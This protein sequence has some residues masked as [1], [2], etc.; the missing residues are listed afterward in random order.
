[1]TLL[2]DRVLDRFE[3]RGCLVV[4]EA[5]VEPVVVVEVFQVCLVDL[6]ALRELLRSAVRD[7]A[8]EHACETLER[9]AFHDAQLVVQVEAVALQFVVD[10]L[11]R[12]LVALDAFTREHLDVDHRAAHARRHAQRRVL[13]VRRLLAED[14]AQQLLFR[15]QLG[16]A[17]RRHLADQ[18]VARFDFRTDVHDARFVETAKLDFR[19]VRDIARDFFR[20]E[21]RVACDDVQLFDVDRRVAIVRDD[22]LRDQDRILEVVA[23]PRHERDQHVLA[24]RELAQVR[25]RAVGQHV[26]ARDLVAHLHDRTLIDVRV[27]V[28]TRVLDQVIDVDADFARDRFVIVHANDDTARVDVIDDAAAQRLHRRARVD[29]HGTLDA[30]TDDGLLRTQTRHGLTLHVRAHQRTVRIVVLEE[31][32]QRGCNRHDLRRRDV[33][34]LDAVRRDHHRFAGFTRRHEFVDERAIVADR[35]VCLRD[36][37]AAFLDRRQ[38]V[39]LVGHLAVDDLAVRRLEEAVFVQVRI[40]RERV[41]ETDVRT[42]RR[43]DRAHAAVVGRVHVADFEARAL[44]RQ[45]ARAQCG[46]AAL[47]RDFRQRVGL[48]HELRQLRRAEE[49]ANRRRNR[50]RVDQVVRHQVF[51]LGLAEALLH[52]AFD[53]HEARAELVFRQF[54]DAAHAPVAEVVDVVDFALAVAQLDENLD[55]RE[56]VVVLQRHRAGDFVTADAAVELHAADLRQVV[57]VFAVEQAIE[58][59]LDGFFRRRLARTHHPVDRDARGRLVDGFVDTQRRRDVRTLVQ[60]V[61]VERLDFLD[62]RFAQLV[63]HAF[64][65]LVVGVRDHFARIAVDDV[66]RKHAAE[67]IVFGHRDVLGLRGFEIANVLRVD[68]L[69]LLDDDLAFTI[70]DVEAC[71]FAAQ[72]LGHELHLRAFVHQREVVEDEEVREDLLRREADRLQQDRDRHLATAVDAEVQH[73]LRIEFEV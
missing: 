5:D 67:Q 34:V 22:A 24:E 27:L 19:E 31:R 33:H 39:D 16:F 43:F 35:R 28:R 54:A 9:V 36:H 14:R 6:R 72:A 40:Q 37:V 48:V 62:L 1:M 11:L 58:Q 38:I 69:V 60:I 18:H 10:D 70:G 2:F 3:L 13:H 55:R 44:A 30:G 73:V 65:D 61:R 57:R 51:A 47:V 20:P 66:L 45:T 64:R 46:N 41:D 23:V 59:R 42:F 68:P 32:N 63:E 53:A 21:L 52:R 49:L 7:L 15:R 12:T 17:L 50:L 56:D 8:H 4:R 29:R 26:A 71:D 25:R